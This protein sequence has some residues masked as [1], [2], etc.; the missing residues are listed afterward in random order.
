[1]ADGTGQLGRQGDEKGGVVVAETALLQLLDH[2]HAEQLAVLG[3]GD[4]Q[5]G[6][7]ALLPSDRKILVAGV[8]GGVVHVDGLCTLGHQAHQA[9]RKAESHRESG[10]RVEPLGGHQHQL[11]PAGGHQI[12]RT[13][14][15]LEGPFH[16]L[17]DDVQDPRQ[18]VGGIDLLYDAAQDIQHGHGRLGAAMCR[19]LAP[20]QG[21]PAPQRAPSDQRNL[22]GRAGGRLSNNRGASSFRASS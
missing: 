1:M 13:D 20:R 3:D 12:H 22:P 8:V 17:D 5:E 4:P 2:Q 21:G 15:D 18:A 11:T 6:V 7:I 9:L 10:L 14:I 16:P 19:A